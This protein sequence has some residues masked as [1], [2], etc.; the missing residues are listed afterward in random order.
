MWVF[1]LTVMSTGATVVL[2]S[3]SPLYPDV[4]FFPKILSKFK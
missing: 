1:V 4:K 2:Y 3:G